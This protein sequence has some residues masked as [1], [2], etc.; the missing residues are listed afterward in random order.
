M[1][2][3]DPDA[4]R[5]GTVYKKSNGLYTVHTQDQVVTCELSSKLRKDLVLSAQSGRVTAVRDI[6]TVDP[7]A[8][9]DIVR[10]I[11]PNG[12]SGLIV[13][14]LP[15]RSR[16]SRREAAGSDRRH[17]REQIIVSNLDQVVP[18]MALAQPAANWN[19]L[20]RYLV[21][22]G[23]LGLPALIVMTKADLARDDRESLAIL[24]EYR[25]IGY[26]VILTSTYSGEGLVE[27]RDAL[28][29]QVSALIG[30][31]GVGKTTL[32]NAVQPGLGLRVK[33]VSALTQKGR[34]TTTHLEM[35]PLEIGGAVTDTPGTRE[36]GL[37][38]VDG[39]N[40]AQFYPEV[41]ALAGTCRFGLDC[42]HIHEP[43]CA[44]RR[45]VE[46]GQIRPRR[47]ESMVRLGR[48]LGEG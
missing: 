18:V 22:A 7:V 16:L 40:I 34:H 10:Y 20:D 8:V 5:E 6:Q 15:R 28:R 26:R 25:A 41:A 33:T 4:L 23:S 47:Y 21:S 42:S 1:P 48:Q 14:V 19:L 9:G 13:A 37:W 27:L 17:A 3:F 2:S 11:P 35:F 45:A 44:V 29:G 38:Q 24:A 46:T 36:F 12:G 31:S 32:L 43:G 30:K 39:A